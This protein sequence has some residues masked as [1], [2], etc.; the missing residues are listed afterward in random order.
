MARRSVGEIFIRN[1]KMEDISGSATIANAF[2]GNENGMWKEYL[3]AG[4]TC[5]VS[6][7]NSTYYSGTQSI[8][9]EI[10]DGAAGFYYLT[11]D[12]TT[13]A[14]NAYKYGIPIR[15]STSYTL[16]AYIKRSGLTSNV[17][18]ESQQFASDG[19]A[20]LAYTSTNIGQADTDFIIATQNF[21]SNAAAD[22][23][24][25]AFYTSG[26]GTYWIDDVKLVDNSISRTAS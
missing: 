22:I 25:I 26:T 20:R 9:A 1:S 8:K 7:D 15:P 18:M 17:A 24:G 11:I 23:L 3:T 4:G 12:T 21:T 19:G 2:V 5:T 10:T 14:V 16:T 6:Y 13:T